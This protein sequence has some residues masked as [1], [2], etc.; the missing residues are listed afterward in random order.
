[1]TAVPAVVLAR[2]GGSYRVLLGGIERVA[3]LRGKAR[4]DRDRAV[5][6]DR[7]RI[8]PAT[9]TEDTL[10]IDGVEPRS[11]LLSR[12]TPEGRGQRPIA[13]NVDQVLIVTAT[14]RPEPIF[15][16]IDRLL[17]VAEANELPALVVANK[18]DLRGA[19]AIRAHLA[20]TGYSL[21][22]VSAQAG[23]GLGELAARLANMESVFTGP[24]GAGKSSLLNAVE[25]NLGLRVG[26][27]SLKVQ[28]GRHTT[29]TATMIPL[30]AGGFVV[31]TPGFSEVGVWDVHPD[32]LAEYFPEFRSMI[33]RCR[34]A[35]CHHV[36]EPGCAVREGVLAGAIPATRHASYLAILADLKA[37]PEAWE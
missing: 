10:G 36:S 30:I 25:P 34:F 26:E 2:E 20:A 24:S 4:Q 29:S 28:R 33:D 6:G 37:V 16:L 31:D 27:L 1:M 35:D 18:V 17:V 15:Q 5:A 13:A 7:V 3:V 22:E 8:D 14:T 21:L 12:R 32:G 23:T 9:L 19:D 11:S